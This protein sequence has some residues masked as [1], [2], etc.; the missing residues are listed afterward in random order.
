MD[1]RLEITRQNIQAFKE[2][3]CGLQILELADRVAD[4]PA[5]VDPS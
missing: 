5:N 1:R 2:K 3:I 4:G